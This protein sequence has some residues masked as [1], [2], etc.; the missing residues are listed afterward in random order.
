LFCFLLS[1]I[2]K[3][4]GWSYSHN[5]SNKADSRVGVPGNAL[6]LVVPWDSDGLE[7]AGSGHLPHLDRAVLTPTGQPLATRVNGDTPHHPCVPTVH[8]AWKKEGNS[9]LAVI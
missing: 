4:V 3:K 9:R 8:L 2:A 6:D 5:N 7:T 1:E